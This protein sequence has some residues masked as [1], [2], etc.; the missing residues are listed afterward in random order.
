MYE[1]NCSKQLNLDPKG[2][3]FVKNRKLN[4]N[5]P[6]KINDINCGDC[7]MSNICLSSV[8]FKSW[9]VTW[10]NHC[11]TI[12]RAPKLSSTFSYFHFLFFIGKTKPF[13][14]NHSLAQ[15]IDQEV[16]MQTCS[17]YFGK[18]IIRRFKIWLNFQLCETSFPWQTM[19]NGR[20]LDTHW[21]TKILNSC[22]YNTFYMQEVY[23][24]PTSY[25]T[26]SNK[27]VMRLLGLCSR[28]LH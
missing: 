5:P 9:Y 15:P 13:W 3:K 17:W 8:I 11:P 22:T 7:K 27:Y 19:L 24:L 18:D 12:L 1:D 10:T 23:T 28:S 4:G 2:E 21:L 26:G 16:L 6:K 25:T 14:C 20:C